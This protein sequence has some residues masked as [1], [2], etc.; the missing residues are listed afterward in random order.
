MSNFLK[1]KN[2][3]FRQQ[4]HEHISFETNSSWGIASFVA[5]MAVHLLVF[6][7]SLSVSWS[8]RDIHFTK[9]DC[10]LVYSGFEDNLRQV[11]TPYFTGAESNVNEKKIICSPSL[12]FDSAHMKYADWTGHNNTHYS[13]IV[14][15]SLL[16]NILLMFSYR[17]AGRGRSWFALGKTEGLCSFI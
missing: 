8:W 9:A 6:F 12:M 11:Q 5:F 3:N 4:Y 7:L 13:C 14:S 10:S 1:R 2:I 17:L 15:R 16:L